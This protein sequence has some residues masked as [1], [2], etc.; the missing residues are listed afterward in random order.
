M[1]IFVITDYCALAIQKI[2]MN[3]EMSLK[4]LQIKE[5]STNVSEVLWGACA[6]SMVVYATLKKVTIC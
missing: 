1:Q 3:M 6:P 2:Y 5:Q 4:A